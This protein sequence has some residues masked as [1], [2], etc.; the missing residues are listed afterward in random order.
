[1][2]IDATARTNWFDRDGRN[3][4][5]FR[6]EYPLA[7]AAH[8]AAIA[9]GTGR[10]LDV[11]CG[12]GQ[13]TVQL[14]GHFGEVIGL[15]PSR[16][17]VEN[18]AAHER[19]TYLCAPAEDIPLNDGCADLIAAAQA[20]HWFDRPAF[21]AE[22]RRLAAPDAVIALI[23][24]G[25]LRLD[26]QPLNERFARFYHDEIGPFWPPER[27]LVDRG[28]ADMDFPFDELP[29]PALS[30]ERDWSL[31]EFLGYVSTWSAVRRVGEAGRTE[32]LDAFV[33]DFSRIWADPGQA[34]RVSWPIN[35][36]IG[37]L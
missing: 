5:L 1:M 3:Y 15:D 28:Y 26:D 10:A 19:V 4:A 29:A 37:R 32:I 21:Y 7:L 25:V 36:R 27:K 13:L 18:A 6:P 9:P 34:R 14:A 35:M 31:G 30:I 24:Y 16:E 2:P 23:S 20:A 12:T 8:L 33:R 22:A 17:Q 11:G